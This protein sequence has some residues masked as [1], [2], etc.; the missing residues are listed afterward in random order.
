MKIF[1]SFCKN[2]RKSQWKAENVPM[3]YFIPFIFTQYEVTPREHFIGF[4]LQFLQK[5]S[6][7]SLN[8]MLFLLY[9][10]NFQTQNLVPWD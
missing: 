6:K 8:K 4:L 7:L 5:E 2:W 10:E 3:G 1:D 9:E